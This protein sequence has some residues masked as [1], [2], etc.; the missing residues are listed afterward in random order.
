[1]SV[2]KTARGHFKDQLSGEMKSINVPEWDTVLYFKPISTFA[3]EQKILELHAKGELVAALIETLI[4]KAFTKEGKRMFNQ[5]DRDILMREVDP[6]V[7]IAICSVIN[8]S[9]EKA[10]ETLGN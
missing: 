2:L 6:N 4:Q 7:I 5:S 8:E 9:K 1:M 3:Q 10:A